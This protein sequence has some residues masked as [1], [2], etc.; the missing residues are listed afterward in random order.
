MIETV[1]FAEFD[2]I[3]LL[4]ESAEYNHARSFT[5]FF[6]FFYEHLRTKVHE[7]GR[8]KILVGIEEL[9]A[10]KLALAILVVAAIIPHRIAR[11]GIV[12]EV[13]GDVGDD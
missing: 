8:T 9:F 2:E 4:V 13:V 10:S 12:A 11:I 3:H 7:L 6:G 5:R 1:T